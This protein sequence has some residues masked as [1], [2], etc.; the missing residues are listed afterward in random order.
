MSSSDATPTKFGGDGA[1][2]VEVLANHVTSPTF[3]VY[4][5]AK[6]KGREA[7]FQK[8]KI[9]AVK[10]LMRDLYKVLRCKLWARAAN[11]TQVPMLSQERGPA[12]P[13]VPGSHS[14][15]WQLRRFGL[16]V[17]TRSAHQLHNGLAFKKTMWT[18][19]LKQVAHQKKKTFKLKGDDLEKWIDVSFYRITVMCQ[20]LASRLR[21]NQRWAQRVVGERPDGDACDGEEEG[22]EEGDDDDEGAP[23]DEGDDTLFQSDS[24]QAKRKTGQSADIGAE[25]PK[26]KKE[27]STAAED[28]FD[29]GFC[30]EQAS[31]SK[32]ADR[33]LFHRL[34]HGVH[35]SSQTVHGSSQTVHRSSQTVCKASQ[36]PSTLFGDSAH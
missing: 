3:F 27:L 17:N 16:A 12:R 25:G 1:Q 29:I 31:D 19:A 14:V 8:Q 24:G 21:K 4:K 9:W 35:G 34:S 10:E 33:D 28:H 7:P 23:E 30:Q 6:Q 20:H 18:N 15:A 26:R 11:Q 5:Q 22:G 2:L 32:Q 36:A 13:Q